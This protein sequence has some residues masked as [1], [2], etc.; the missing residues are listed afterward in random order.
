M[1]TQPTNG[2]YHGHTQCEHSI[3]PSRKTFLKLIPVFVFFLAS[4]FSS[5]A[6]VQTARTVTIN[7]YI[8]GFFEYLP[9]GYETSGEEYPLLIFFHGAG[10]RGNGS[11]QLSRV[12][13]N[14][15]PK[16]IKNGTFPKSFTVNGKSHKFI[17][18]SPQFT[19]V[20]PGNSHVNDIIDYAVKN[21]R[22]N[23]KRIYLTG[24]SMGGGMIFLYLGVN[25]TYAKRI[26]AMVPVCQAYGYSNGTAKVISDAGIRTWM[27]H[28]NGDPT[29]G[30]AGTLNYLAGINAL[31]SGLAKATIFTSGSHDA[32]SKTYD[33]SFKEDGL[34]VYEWMLQF[35]QGAAKPPA[36][37]P[38]AVNAG[39]DIAVRLPIN[40]VT[41][42]GVSSDKDGTISS[43]S[44]K[45]IS[46]RP[47]AIINPSKLTTEV[48][49]LEVG[50]YEFE[51]T[52]TDDKG[53]SSKDV[54]K[55]TIN[56]ANVLPTVNAGEDVEITLPINEITLVGTGTDTDGSILSYQWTKIL[57][58]NANLLS[59]GAKS[60]KI[61]KLDAGEY[62]FQLKVIDN[63]GGTSTDEVRVK[64]HKVINKA[65]IANA[66]Q[67]VVIK[68]PTSSVTLFGSGKDEDGT[69]QA[70]FWT[71]LKGQPISILTPGKA[72]TVLE[73]LT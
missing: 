11:T 51:L 12:L 28:N 17:V 22:V 5:H 24:L 9:E 68:L 48:Q 36:N 14:G 43:V 15:V 52:V 27:T 29:V 72:T 67:D 41:L 21:Y 69:I 65:P 4:C 20:P 40:S 37:L 39:A 55:V 32:W 44:W 73:G 46:G 50:I 6:Q 63:D 19:D 18:I 8:K 38:P 23:T 47:V 35:E 54:I 7:N 45:L 49:N 58:G 56:A 71:Q 42:K 64:V 3:L 53:A 57:G 30:V 59:P 13:S 25:Q 70:Y 2:V 10:E 31:N 61:E 34:N 60:T 66:G 33:P 26:A 1:K 16:L 62:V